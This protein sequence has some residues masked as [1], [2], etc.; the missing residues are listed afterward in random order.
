MCRDECEYVFY[1]TFTETVPSWD[2]VLVFT[3]VP[4]DVQEHVEANYTESYDHVLLYLCVPPRSFLR[5]GK[6]SCDPD[7]LWLYMM[8]LGNVRA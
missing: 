1:A 5:T 8:F 6:R 4:G 2:T 3:F 7:S